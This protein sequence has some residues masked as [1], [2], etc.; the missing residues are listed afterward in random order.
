MRDVE[1]SK[2]PKSLRENGANWTAELLKER[3]KK[4]PDPK[5]VRSLTNRYK[6]SDVRDALARMYN[7]LCCYCEAEIGVVAT[8]HIEHRKPKNRFPRN[9]F[10]WTN[11]HLACPNCNQAKG[12]RWIATHP[13]LDAVKDIPIRNH[14]TYG[15]RGGLGVKRSART[16]RG[17]TTMQLADLN[18]PKLRDARA[19]VALDVLDLIQELNSDPDSPRTSELLLELE[20]KTK[21]MYGSLVRWCIDR[22][23]WRK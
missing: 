3:R 5:R 8:D 11:L 20:E 23:L 18:R 17:R 21:D 2:M 12:Q 19:R 13:I 1:R 22:F 15:M 4:K 10:T 9:C 14:L 7:G 16:P 6:R